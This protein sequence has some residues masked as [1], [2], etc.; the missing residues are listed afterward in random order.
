MQS[1]L[2]A[3]L[4]QESGTKAKDE[5][6]SLFRQPSSRRARFGEEHRGSILVS[7]HAKSGAAAGRR[8][9][10][11]NVGGSHACCDE[12]RSSS[13]KEVMMISNKHS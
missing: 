9:V 13:S 11:H 7:R 4:F 10:S 1:L 6:G 8:R 3:L 12:S 5:Y 2:T